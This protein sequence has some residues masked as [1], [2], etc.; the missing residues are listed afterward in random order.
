MSA[1]ILLLFNALLVSVC[2]NSYYFIKE[3]KL[4]IVPAVLLFVLSFVIPLL[5]TERK[6]KKKFIVCH[7]GINCLKVFLVSTVATVVFQIVSIF[8]LSESFGE[9]LISVLVCTV[10]EAAVFWAGIICVY[11]SSVQLGI[12]LRVLGVIFGMWPIVNL[13]MLSKI[14][15]VCS[16]EVKFESEKFSLNLDEKRQ[17]LCSTKYPILLV[18]G[19]F[20]RDSDFFNY[21][22]R[23]PEQLMLC[24]AR[25]FYGEHASASSVADSAAELAERIRQIVSETGCEKLNIIA[26]SKGGLDCRYAMEKFGITPYVASL[27]TINTPHRGCK[28]ADVLLEKIPESAR[29]KIAEAYNASLRKFGDKNPDF[30][31]AVSDLTASSCERLNAEM[32]MPKGVYCQSTGSM[33]ARASGGKFPLNLSYHLVKYFDGPNDGLVGE[34]SFRWGEKYTY[35]KP[36]GKRGISHGDMIDLMRENIDEFDVREWY[37]GLVAELK[38]KGL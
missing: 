25:I 8:V 26:H 34:D 27:T 5:L 16:R 2:A 3:Q 24:G 30:L 19:V 20:F 1:K 11:I 6:N 9:W 23:I 21:W 35:L 38:N 15:S 32:P 7:Y 37:V 12:K 29:N 36:N 22:G 10:V 31:A 14:I 17:N 13:V 28:F 18:H 33:L 4:L